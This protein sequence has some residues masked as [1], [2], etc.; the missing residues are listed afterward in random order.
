MK[1]RRRQASK[2]IA[3][4]AANFIMTVYFLIMVVV[5]P[6]YVKDGYWEIGK[7]KAFFFIYVSAVTVG[8]M[9]IVLTVHVWSCRKQMSITDF[10]K[11]MS[12]T[13]W[14]VDGYLA[15]VLLS[16]L[17]TDYKNEALLGADGWYMGLVSQLLFIGIYFLFSRYFRWNEKFLYVVL[18]S[19]GL[20]FLLGILNRYSVYPITMYGQQPG[21]I[22]TLGNINWFCGYWAVVSPLGILWYWNSWGGWRQVAA[23]IYVIIAFLSG[24]TQGGSS[25]YL[26]LA[27]VFLL[28]FCLSFRENRAAQRFLEL[29]ILFFLSC[30]L[31]RLLRYLPVLTM[32]YEDALGRIFTDTNLTLYIGLLVVML[33]LLFGY[34]VRRKNYDI[35]E[36]KGIRKV[37][38]ILLLILSAGYLVLLIINT[39]IPGGIPILSEQQ[40]FIFNETWGNSRGATWLSGLLAYQSMSLLQKFV[41]VGADCFAEYIYTVPDLA[42]RVYAWFGDSRLTNAHNEWLTILVNGG[43]FGLV[44]YA[45][46][47]L[48]AIPRFLKKSERKADA[49]SMR[50][51]CFGLYGT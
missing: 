4:Q 14:F 36:H 7:A 1:E 32:N 5:F 8:I 17:F 21:F 27:G 6:F 29:C 37:I 40:I 38:L 15:A 10:Y 2:G 19:S 39:C 50:S 24:V 47:F 11:K 42:T 31:A 20:I 30:Q 34:L 23:G 45:G 18:L 33:Y 9:L 44:C 25:A 12:I 26:A 41:G 35:A 28:L 22:S 13:D 16:Y 46:I 51:R 43:A 48:S 49:L 3:T